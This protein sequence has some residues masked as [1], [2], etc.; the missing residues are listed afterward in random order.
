MRQGKKSRLAYVIL[1][2]IGLFILIAGSFAILREQYKRLNQELSRFIYE[3]LSSYTEARQ[4]GIGELAED[5]DRILSGLAEAAESAGLSAQNGKVQV[6]LDQFNKRNDDYQVYYQEISQLL[7]WGVM[8]DAPQLQE[9]LLKGMGGI[10]DI[11]GS[12]ESG[13]KKFF[14]A[15]EPVREEGNV[16]GVFFLKVDA[17]TLISSRMESTPF[18]RIHSLIVK[19]DGS[20][21]YGNSS[22]Y[23]SSGNLFS[24]IGTNGIEGQYAE[25]IK[26]KFEKQEPFTISFQGQENVYYISS[27]PLGINQWNLVNFV[28]S[29]DVLIQ[30]ELIFDSLFRTGALLVTLTLTIC[31]AIALGFVRQK[32][33][34]QMEEQR[35]AVLSQFTDTILFEYDY[36]SDTVEFTS[37]ARNKLKL[38]DLTITGVINQGRGSQLIHPDDWRNR[39]SIQLAWKAWGKDE[40]LHRRIRLKSVSGEY[41]W[42]NCQFR[43][44]KDSSGR[45]CRLVGKLEDIMEQ[46]GREERLKNEARRDLLTGMYNRFGKRLIEKELASRKKGLFI[47]IDLDN[48]KEINDTYG[49]VAGDTAL[50]CVAGDL[51]RLFGETGV[52]ARMGGDEFVVFVPEEW[53][54]E[55]IENAA[56]AIIEAF[57]NIESE[58]FP[59]ITISASIGI[60]VAP[61]D[62]VTYGELYHASDKAMYW[63]KNNSKKG[64]AFYQDSK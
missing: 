34:L 26:D 44:L 4:Y 53:D 7:E 29:P 33:R 58:E 47:M 59:E 8:K 10:S 24:S 32:Q 31:T 40:M 1:S 20:I 27:C 46:L 62:G 42:F 25:E 55:R 13:E 35:Y 54:T 5:I 51:K 3:S 14:F 43:I 28:R 18:K 22:F 49:H 6:Y 2:L 50:T 36:V 45:H 11:L 38:D 16:T 23:E 39:G 15:A 12:E 61:K 64:Y 60:A 9:R 30:S 48:F 56:K 21:L 17:E 63:V 52:V 57:R 19:P 37:N 41:R